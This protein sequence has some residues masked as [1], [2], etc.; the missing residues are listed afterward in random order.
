MRPSIRHASKAA[1]LL[2]GSAALS[3]PAFADPT[4]SLNPKLL[5]VHANGMFTD[6]TGADNNLLFIQAKLKEQRPGTTQAWQDTITPKPSQIAFGLA[7]NR[8]EGALTQLLQVFRQRTTSALRALILSPQDLPPELQDLQK[9]AALGVDV[10]NAKLDPDLRAHVQYY[11]NQV[12]QGN[13]VTVVAHSQGNLYAN[14][15]W[16][17]LFNGASPLP[18]N[19]WNMVSVATPD[20]YVGGNGPYTTSEDDFIMNAVRFVYPGTLPA[21]A[22]NDKSS[23][24][25]TF[26]RHGLVEAYL[27]GNVTKPKVLSQII[28]QASALVAPPSTVSGGIITASLEWDAN[29][30]KGIP[31]DLDL[32]V[33]EPTDSGE[34]HLTYNNPTAG[35][36]SIDLDNRDGSGPEHYFLPCATIKD[37]VY[38][39]AVNYYS[40]ASSTEAR[41]QVQAGTTNRTYRITL[42]T[43]A[44]VAGNDSPKAVVNVSVTH[45][46]GEP[47]FTLIVP[48]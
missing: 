6:Q 28:D 15:A 48:K 5:I 38:R 24:Q 34:A 2:I 26:I 25:S 31:T 39:F 1:A 10:A 18:D 29:S 44:G 37:G 30:G 13:R 47:K 19:S 41:V 46:N 14:E 4:C 21:N 40:G 23:E 9:Q 3:T 27:S 17:L 20:N 7:Y 12:L 16:N 8:N 22:K 36:G 11:R 43:P 42:S 35:A 32:H 45:E 33:F